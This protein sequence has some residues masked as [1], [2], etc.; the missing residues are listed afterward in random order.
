M[1]MW[2]RGVDSHGFFG[3]EPSRFVIC[4]Y[5]EL[6]MWEWNGGQC[7]WGERSVIGG[8]VTVVIT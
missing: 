4:L 2:N 5:K 7:S 1:A 6:F 3:N 8:N